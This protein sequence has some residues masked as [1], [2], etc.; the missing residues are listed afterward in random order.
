[1]QGRCHSTHTEEMLKDAIPNF[2]AKLF[3]QQTLKVVK[4]CLGKVFF[5]VQNKS[6]KWIYTLE[7]NAS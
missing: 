4:H 7:T 1:M 2:P 5:L 6:K 3:Y